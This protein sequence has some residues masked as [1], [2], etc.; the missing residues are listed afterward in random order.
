MARILA[1]TL[2]VQRTTLSTQRDTLGTKRET[3]AIQKESLVH[4]RSIDRKTGG[5][6]PPTPVSAAPR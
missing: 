2:Q 6:A 3:L 5:T 1:E 4:I